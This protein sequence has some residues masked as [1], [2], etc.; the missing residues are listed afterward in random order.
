MHAQ[1]SC[2]ERHYR[3]RDETE[4]RIM[5]RIMRELMR[6]EITA[7]QSELADGSLAHLK[8]LSC[9]TYYPA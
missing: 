1:N 2:Q 3:E 4:N 8:P 7:M 5:G 9:E 6:P